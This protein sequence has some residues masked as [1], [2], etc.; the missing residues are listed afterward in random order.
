[1]LLMCSGD[2]EMNPWP[3]N[4]KKCPVCQLATIKIKFKKCTCG[5]TFHKKC[6][7]QPP[8][9]HAFPTATTQA[10]TSHKEVVIDKDSDLSHYAQAQSQPVGKPTTKGNNMGIAEGPA[11]R[12]MPDQ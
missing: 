12:Q 4:C 7:R 8:K 3:V 6:H 10:A 2:V 5:H 1:M 11:G 9:C